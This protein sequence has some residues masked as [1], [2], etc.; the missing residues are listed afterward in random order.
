MKD[1]INVKKVKNKS[2][3]K[4]IFLKEFLKLFVKITTV[5]VIV[6]LLFT[7]V[8]GIFRFNNIE[9]SP[10]IEPSDMVLFYR[11][12]K[13]YLISDAVVYGYK[14]QKKI[15]RVV[16][17]PND[18]VDIDKTGLKVNGLRVNETKIYKK[19]SPFKEGIKFPIKLKEDEY[20][21]LA[22]NRD[23]SEDSRVF[24]PVK[25]KDIY[26]K[27]FSIFRRRNI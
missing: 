2:S 6:S 21:I 12:N 16:A 7:F 14:N 19:T 8:F 5:M 13:K 4:K 23:F 27:V 26:G 17:L 24:G 25:K 15:A 22:D 3:P 10:N 20:F 11:L 1:L 18:T 9:M